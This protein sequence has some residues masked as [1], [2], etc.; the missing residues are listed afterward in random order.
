MPIPI[1]TSLHEC[2]GHFPALQIN[3]ALGRVQY[4]QAGSRAAA[5]DAPPPWVLLHGIGSGSASWVAQLQAAFSVAAP[6]CH[7]L[8]WDAPG[9]GNS[10][11]VDPA[12]PKAEDYARRLWAWLDA[13]DIRQP[14]V[15]VGHSLGAIMAASATRLQPRRVARLVLLAPARGYGRAEPEERQQKLNERL[16]NLHTLGP[17]GMADRRG[18]AMLSPQAT[19]GQLAFIQNVMA[20]IDPAG[21]TQAAR[22]LAHADLLGDL[23]VCTCPVSVAS[24]TADRITPEAACR[25]VATAVGVAWHSLGEAGHACPLEAASAVNA[26][27]GLPQGAFA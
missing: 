21:Y 27:L 8:A 14:V 20:Q 9:Y 1:D 2:L 22:L 17:R 18:A 12:E 16:H 10:T 23:A 11:P 13:L 24:G 15:L 25:E 19:P 5:D 3:T 4:R 6:D 7:V 26:L